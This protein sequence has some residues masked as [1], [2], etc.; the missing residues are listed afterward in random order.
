MSGSILPGGLDMN[1]RLL[2]DNGEY[3]ASEI[4]AEYL[5]QTDDGTVIKVYNRGF[6]NW[7]DRDTAHIVTTPQFSVDRNSPYSFLNYGVYAGTLQPRSD[8]SGVEI[9]IFKLL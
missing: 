4:K 8:G 9:E 3:Y 1:T 2:N 7:A 6:R 5:I